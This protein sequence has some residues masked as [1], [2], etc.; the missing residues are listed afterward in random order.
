[1]WKGI[2]SDLTDVVWHD[3]LSPQGY[4][5]F[6]HCIV[7]LISYN[8]HFHFL[9]YVLWLLVGGLSTLRMVRTR[10]PISLKQ[11]NNLTLPVRHP[12]GGSS[13]VSNCRTDSS[14]PPLWNTLSPPH[15]VLAV[16]SLCLPQ[17]RRRFEMI[18]FHSFTVSPPCYNLQWTPTLF[19][20]SWALWKDRTWFPCSGWQEMCLN[21]C[22]MPQWGT[23][24]CSW[25][26][27]VPP[28]HRPVQAVGR[29]E[30]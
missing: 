4:G 8:I 5:L 2:M 25:A 3:I 15:A 1:M 10:F 22:W 30:S 21:C 18:T 17:D 14:S 29:H 6:G 9:F 27:D 26:A 11:L 7:L 20:G 19:Q 13:A 12:S 28:K 23:W 16:P 24:Q